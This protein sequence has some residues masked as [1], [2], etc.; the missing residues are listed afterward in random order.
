[1]SKACATLVIFTVL[2]CVS[3]FYFTTENSLTFFNKL[4]NS[5]LFTKN[6]NEG[7]TYTHDMAVRREMEYI[8]RSK[9]LKKVCQEQNMTHG[10][11][12][13][14][15]LLKYMFV[16]LEHQVNINVKTFHL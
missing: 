1:M 8:K 3:V 5:T 16:S 15:T 14:R 6:N 7:G 10:T 11:M 4:K 2:C 9:L 13:E 12:D